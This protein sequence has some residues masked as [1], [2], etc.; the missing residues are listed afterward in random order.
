MSKKYFKY[1]NANIKNRIT[2]DCSIRA[3]ATALNKSY[4]DVI[5]EMTEFVVAD[6]YFFDDIRTISN[7]LKSK[8]WVKQKQPVK[9]NKTKYTGQEFCKKFA[10]KNVNYVANI[11]KNHI[12]AIIN[13]KVNDTWDSSD[14]CIGNYWMKE[15]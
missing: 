12:V 1:Y 5:K 15:E 2:P 3:L 14:R 11:G 7:Y 8:G 13:K 4:V 10:K 9:K 6:G